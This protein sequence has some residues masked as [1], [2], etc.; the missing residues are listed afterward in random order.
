MF[1]DCV[2]VKSR[3][4]RVQSQNNGSRLLTLS[5]RPSLRCRLAGLATNLFAFVPDTFAFVWFGLAHRAN[6]GGKLADELLI[7][8]FDYNVRLVWARDRQALRDF[9]M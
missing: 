2:E 3:E 5:S 1:H 6:F 8:A 7:G 9:L 4:L